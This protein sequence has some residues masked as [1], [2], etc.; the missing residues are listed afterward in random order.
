MS[1][2]Q[3]KALAT[4]GPTGVALPFDYGDKAGDGMDVT[5]DDLNLP[6]LVLAQTESKILI[7]G[8]S[9]FVPGGQPGMIL[10][11]ATKEYYDATPG[12][13]LIP[14]AIKTS[15]IEWLPDNAGFVAEHEM[16][17]DIA[18]NAKANGN[19][20]GANDLVKTKTMVAVRVDADLNP[21][22][23]VVI[24][25]SA[26][27]LAA[28]SDY[29]TAVNTAKATKNAPIYANLIRLVS[30]DDKNRDG[31][32]YKNFG[33]IAARDESGALVDTSGIT[34]KASM[35]KV[36]ATAAVVTS[37]IDPA[38]PAFAAAEQLRDQFLSGAATVDHG[39]SAADETGKKDKH[40]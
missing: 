13:L 35:S 11:T 8:E 30:F 22:D 27:K 17:T 29:F 2:K 1:K 28:W 39:A 4:T 10:N 12:L 32:R 24:P 20:N 18:I 16:G 15:V 3:E 37:L 21:I 40:F 23:F 6:L 33:M 31:K 36:A 38:S 9:K 34:D 25:F 7:D 14:A 19:K 26:S 5:M